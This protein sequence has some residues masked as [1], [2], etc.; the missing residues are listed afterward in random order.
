MSVG[1]VDVMMYWP[2]WTDVDDLVP[3]DLDFS[4]IDRVAYYAVW[5]SDVPGNAGQV[6]T[7]PGF[8]TSAATVVSAAHA[9][10]RLAILT[11]GGDGTSGGFTLL[12]DD[13]KQN[14]FVSQVM[15]HVGQFGFDGVDFDWEWP[16]SGNNWILSALVAKFRAALP[17]PQNK[18]VGAG[19]SANAEHGSGFPTDAATM[20][21]LD[22]FAAQT[23]GNH[24]PGAFLHAG[25]VGAIHSANGDNFNHLP[26]TVP[27]PE[28]PSFDNSL[29]YWLS[30]GVPRDKLWFGLGFYGTRFDNKRVL[31]ENTGNVPPTGVV[32]PYSVLK[33]PAGSA[34]VKLTDWEAVAD[35]WTLDN[36]PGD[37]LSLPAT[38]SIQASV[39]FAAAERLPGLIVW[40]AGLDLIAGV[41]EL[42]PSI[43]WTAGQQESIWIP[44]SAFSLA[45]GSATLGVW[46]NT[47]S[48]EHR[49]PAW[50]MGYASTSSLTTTLV[51]PSG[52]LTVIPVT[53]ILHWSS[54]NQGNGSDQI[55]VTLLWRRIADGQA[56]DGA[57]NVLR[58]SWNTKGLASSEVM[59]RTV[60]GGFSPGGYRTMRLALRRS[61]VTPGLAPSIWI[62]G[63][64]LQFVTS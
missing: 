2:Y 33:P 8:A 55:D 22:W 21:N 40:A 1:S 54:P 64:E 52:L 18:Y 12:S 27:R 39:R 25:H 31:Y 50:Q 53:A 30:R 16:T 60:I 47:A 14:T 44:A 42:V 38:T 45:E 10:G 9:A 51:L 35:Y 61:P 36:P 20:G 49:I 32:E 13:A 43:K 41:Q 59:A 19:C 3:S 6:V 11:L 24:T 58:P 62:I 5:P 56:V 15:S 57:A 29:D 34:W 63:L 4:L 28:A 37:V 17:R 26:G 46:G 7:P 48:P 23:Y